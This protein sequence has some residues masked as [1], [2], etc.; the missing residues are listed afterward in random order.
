VA[1]AVLDDPVTGTRVVFRRRSEETQG[2]VVVVEMFLQ[3]Q[4]RPFAAHVH[5]RQ[6]ETID[7]LHGTVAFR[8]GRAETVAGPGHRV[9][10]PAAVPHE[11]HNRGGEVAHV[12]CELRPALGFESLLEAVFGRATRTSVDA[13][14]L[15]A[16]L[17]RVAHANTHFETARAPFP[18]A[19]VQRPALWLG[20]ALGRLL[21]CV[22]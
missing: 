9:R 8:I 7:V 16:L 19:A 5:P 10:V 13:S 17:G 15:R 22:G 20:A 11:F 6:E 18:P 14:G 2:R 1:H 21:G 12:V 4:G 3:P